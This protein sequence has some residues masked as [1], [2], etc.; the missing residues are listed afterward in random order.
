MSTVDPNIAATARAARR[1]RRRPSP[2]LVIIPFLMLAAGGYFLGSGWGDPAMFGGTVTGPS[3]EFWDI[4]RIPA[5]MMLTIFGG[6]LWMFAMF[7]KSRGGFLLGPGA[8]LIT[9]GIGLNNVSR[10]SLEYV[11]S[12]ETLRFTIAAGLVALGAVAVVLGI[13]SLIRFRVVNAK[14]DGVLKGGT[15]TTATVSDQGYTRLGSSGRLF[16][17]VTFTFVDASGVQR[18]VKKEMVV[19]T[20][21]PIKRG[22]TTRLW[23][24]PAN[25]GKASVIMVEAAMNSQL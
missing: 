6:I 1:A 2:L 21:N 18:W 12:G 14:R 16:T 23:Y 13:V 5:G 20:A 24:D 15:L 10:S 19:L 11:Q 8:A 17:A 9:G 25:P 3:V 4:A 22:D 7:L